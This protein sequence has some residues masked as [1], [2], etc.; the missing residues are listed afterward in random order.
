M[1][2][3]IY[4]LLREPFSGLSHLVGALLALVALY[5]LLHNAVQLHDQLAIV[6]FS[7]YGLSLFLLYAASATYHLL[8]VAP[9]V[10]VILQKW[11]HTMIYVLIAGTYTPLLLLSLPESWRWPGFSV[12]W[13]LAGLGIFFKWARFQSPRWISTALFLGMGWLSIP[14]FPELLKY[15]PLPGFYWIAV[16]GAFYT[17]GAIVYALKKPDPVPGIFGFHEIWHLFVLAGSF[18]Q[19]WA[20]YRY[21]PLR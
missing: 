5:L 20:L 15:F 6:A 19:F 4:R 8:P 3:R 18:S 7:I 10:K 9:R 17:I 1:I 13:F 12:I 14:I 2:Q 21:L 11:D 16:G